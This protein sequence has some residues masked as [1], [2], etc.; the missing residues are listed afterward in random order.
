MESYSTRGN[1]KAKKIYMCRAT[2][3]N[4]NKIVSDLKINNRE[5]IF[6]AELKLKLRS[7]FHYEQIVEKIQILNE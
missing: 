2:H 1:A 5:R 6:V 7:P 4:N 3:R